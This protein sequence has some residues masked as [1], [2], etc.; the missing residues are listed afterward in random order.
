MHALILPHQFETMSESS[1]RKTMQI[2][3]IFARPCERRGG[4]RC[5]RGNVS[6]RVQARI[7]DSRRRVESDDSTVVVAARSLGHFSLV[8]GS[9]CGVAVQLRY[10]YRG[11]VFEQQV[12]A[13]PQR[14]RVGGLADD[15]VHGGDG[16]SYQ[17]VS[18]GR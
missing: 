16:K 18:L 13:G 3:A 1:G 7:I 17:P 15:G 8:G 5:G 2:I 11:P 9:L 4:V 14:A 6:A 12:V 10:P